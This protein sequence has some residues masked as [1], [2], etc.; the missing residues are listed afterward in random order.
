MN[1][2][3]I[4]STLLFLSAMLITSACKKNKVEPADPLPTPEELFY[5]ECGKIPPVIGCIKGTSIFLPNAFTPN[6][7][8]FND[9]FFAFGGYGIK[10]IISFKIYDEA[11]SLIFQESNI[12][13]NVVFGL[14][15]GWD[16]K[17][18]DGSF[19]DGIYNY[20]ISFATLLDEIAEFEGAVCCRTSFPLDCVE[21]EKHLA[22]GTQHDGNG[23]FDSNLP[24]YEECE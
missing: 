19:Q 13:L 18:P 3:K 22:W 21:N 15:Y 24:S 23:G 5:T 14:S 11:G 20:T 17:L 4:V 6:N 16:G 10:E 12:P 8:G 7:D 9:V 2:Y 1:L